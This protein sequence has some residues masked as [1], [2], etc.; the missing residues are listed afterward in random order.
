MCGIVGLFDTR[1][2]RAVDVA[3]LGRMNAVQFHRG[4]DEGGQHAE[5]GV[6]LGHR[7]LSIIDLATG[8]QPLWN[9]DHSVVVVFNGEIYNYRSLI[10]R[11]E[12]AGHVF[13]TRS[14][15]EVIVHAWE[16]WGEACVAEFNGMFAFCLWDRNQRTLF[17]ARD[18]F[19]EKPLYWTLGDDGWFAF[20]SELKS[21]V[22][23]PGQARRVDPAAVED[24]LA[25]GYVP[26]PR[27][28]Y[29]GVHKLPPAHTMTLQVGGAPRIREYWQP[30]FTANGVRTLEAAVPELQERFREAVKLRLV[31][32]VPLGAFLSGGVDS[33]AVVASMAGLQEGP[34]ET[35]SIS[36][37]DPRFNEST[38][39]ANIAQRF[40]TH[41][42]VEQVDSDDFDLIDTLVAAYDEPFADSSALP[43]YR[44]CQ[45]ARKHVTVALSGDAGD[46]NFAGYR[47]YRWHMHEERLRSLLPQ[48]LRG[49]LFGLAGALYP[50]LD[51][52]PQWLRAKT[53]FEALARTSMAAYFHS[54]SVM[55][56]RV[57]LPLYNSA[58]RRELGGYH[59]LEVFR[60]HADRAP[61]DD[62]LAY[63]QYLDLKTWLPGDILTKVDRASM[64]HGLEVRVPLLDHTLVEWIGGLP[65][66][67]KLHRG[68]GKYVFKKSLEGQVPDDILYRPKMGFSVPVG[69]WFRGPLRSRV[70]GLARSE[71][72]AGLGVFNTDTV[73]QL[74]TQHVSGR[75][76]HTAAV[77]SLLMLEGFAR[78]E[79]AA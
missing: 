32:E 74:V 20:A 18:R 66:A 29:A 26:E 44:V 75:R 39:A 5:P 63:I 54:V 3:V 24:Y 19:G 53:T 25:F 46:E 52:A 35:C 28:I 68:E 69:R 23:R 15:T 79:L 11:L 7:R 72:L 78:K 2:Q 64:Q 70:E 13:R 77:W 60:Q 50:K 6:G 4:P 31:S 17:L 45:L 58:F 51:W 22:A 16:E 9:E 42:H 1:E 59:A 61:A 47:R 49:P 37:G 12:A 73:G 8:Q 41:H 57:R 71:A 67:L 55:P 38:Y 30:S 65:S 40:G 43:T 10:P 21:L 48:S 76:D 14:D 34:V 56:D 33:S 27:T 62:A 36:F